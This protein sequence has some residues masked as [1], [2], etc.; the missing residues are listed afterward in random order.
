MVDEAISRRL[1]FGHGYQAFWTVGSG[2]A[3]R[4]WSEL[5]WMAP[6]A[7]NGFR[8]TLLSLGLVGFTTLGL[9]ILRAMHQ[10]AMLQCRAPDEGWLWLNVWLGTFLV[11]NLTESILLAQNDV[12]WTLCVTAIIAFSLRYPENARLSSA[13]LPTRNAAAS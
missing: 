12:F 3:W 13:S 7:H 10:G 9:V 8:E 4:I 1:L 11:M 2:D 6:H 5:G